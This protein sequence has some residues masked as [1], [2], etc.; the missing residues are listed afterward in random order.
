[1]CLRNTRGFLDFVQRASVWQRSGGAWTQG[2]SCSGLRPR[3]SVGGCSAVQ[4]NSWPVNR[5]LIHI[6]F[7]SYLCH[8]TI[9]AILLTDKKEKIEHKTQRVRRSGKTFCS[10]AVYSREVAVGVGF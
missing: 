2:E 9:C 6:G 8:L 7:F 1:M 5:L 3:V 4:F 10:D